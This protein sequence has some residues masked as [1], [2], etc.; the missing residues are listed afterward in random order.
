MKG[1]FLST[2]WFELIPFNRWTSCTALH[3]YKTMLQKYIF[4]LSQPAQSNL[5]LFFLKLCVVYEFTSRSGISTL[6]DSEILQGF[7]TNLSPIC[8]FSSGERR[9]DSTALSSSSY[10]WNASR[11]ICYRY[12]TYF[13]FDSG[14]ELLVKGSSSVSS[15]SISSL[16]AFML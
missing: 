12:Y 14:T 15:F 11:S 6:A 13:F 10:I 3:W 4:V 9:A 8:N 5:C 16:I 7:M 1:W 2:L